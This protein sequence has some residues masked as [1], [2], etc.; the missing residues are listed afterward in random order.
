MSRTFDQVKD[1]LDYNVVL[2]SEDLRHFACYPLF[3]DLKVHL[4]HV[5]LLI[6][7]RRELR[8]LQQLCIDA[9][10]H[11]GSWS[12]RLVLAAPLRDKLLF[13]K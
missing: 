7:L 10:G 3:H 2:A 5:N 6:E 13:N 1:E 8:S 11:H 12:M 4:L 9:S